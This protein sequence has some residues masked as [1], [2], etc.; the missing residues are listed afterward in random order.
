MGNPLGQTDQSGRFRVSL[1][2]AYGLFIVH[3]AR[4]LAPEWA[5]LKEPQGEQLR[6]VLHSPTNL[7]GVVV[8]YQDRPVPD[9]E[10]WVNS[11]RRQPIL[12]RV[13]TCSAPCSTAGRQRTIFRLAAQRMASF[14]LMVFRHT[15]PRC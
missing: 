3:K 13:R 15:S 6:F 8:D 12:P 5:M 1:T 7:S 2:N 14:G 11:V 9:A 10:V 4:D